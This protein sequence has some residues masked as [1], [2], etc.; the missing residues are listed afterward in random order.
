MIER[1]L[2]SSFLG[3]AK[4]MPVLALMGPRQS[5]KTTLA[6]MTFPDKPYVSL[7]EPDRLQEAVE[8]PRLFLK[9]Y[10]NGAVIDEVQRTPDLFSYI[11]SIVDAS[12]K[13]GMFVLTGSHNF[14]LLERISQS[15]AGRVALHTLLPFSMD[16][17]SQTG[18][19]LSLD[20]LIFMGG[21][22]R[23]HDKELS[24][25]AWH[26]DYIRTYV[27]RDVRLVKNIGNLSTFHRFLKMCASRSGQLVN[28]SALGDDC[29]VNYNTV[30]SWIS[31]LEASYLVYLLQPHHRNFNKRLK[32]SP[33][34]YFYD[35][36]LLCAL[37]G[38]QKAEEIVNHPFRGAL[39]ET[40]VLSEI[41]KRFFNAARVP[42]LYFWRDKRDREIDCLIEQGSRLIPVEIKSG[43]TVS[44]D[45]FRH[46][47]Y[48]NRLARNQSGNSYVVYAGDGSHKRA[49]ANLLSWREIG[50]IPLPSSEGRD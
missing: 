33:K 49:Q 37:L 34:L 48:W 5:G 25:T 3:A 42:S 19:N 35:T 7:E 50:E 12:K 24:P 20:E 46:L 18:R 29:G 30:K 41:M 10:P 9:N 15:L 11:Q 21:Y 2:K 40:F 16:E 47:G 43:L 32:K 8:D 23:I 36:G 4:G 13:D 28:F 26:Q 1:E 39:F 14:L 44:D 45:Y 31:V 27:E 22:P 38:I 17:I 6:R